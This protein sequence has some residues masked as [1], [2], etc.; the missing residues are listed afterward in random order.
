LFASANGSRAKA[1]TT[2]SGHWGGHVNGP[3]QPRLTK[4]ALWSGAPSWLHSVSTPGQK[5]G[6]GR[7][8]LQRDET[9]SATV[10]NLC[11]GPAT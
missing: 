9:L 4:S 2:E 7:L 1:G 11:P 10:P 3:F 6:E 8:A 5:S